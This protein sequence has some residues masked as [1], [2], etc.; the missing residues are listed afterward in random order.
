MSTPVERHTK[1]VISKAQKLAALVP[2][3][4]VFITVEKLYEAKQKRRLDPTRSLV[5]SILATRLA[6][7]L[8]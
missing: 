3:Y 2:D 8:K 7:Q 1:E 5:L 6:D 4:G